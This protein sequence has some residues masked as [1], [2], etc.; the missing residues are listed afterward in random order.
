MLLTLDLYCWSKCLSQLDP[1]SDQKAYCFTI[2]GHCPEEKKWRR[3][4]KHESKVTPCVKGA[5]VV[6]LTPVFNWLSKEKA[7]KDEDSSFFS[8]LQKHLSHKH[9]TETARACASAYAA[10]ARRR[11]NTPRALCLRVRRSWGY[12]QNS[13]GAFAKSARAMHKRGRCTIKRRTLYYARSTMKWVSVLCYC[14]TTH[15]RN[16]QV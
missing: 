13:L 9:A 7:L 3:V 16:T 12:V 5:E 10:P 4:I 11:R 6:L 14:Y 15:G 2:K 8:F 1:L